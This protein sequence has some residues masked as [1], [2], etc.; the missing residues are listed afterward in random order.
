MHTASYQ[1]WTLGA[2]RDPIGVHVYAVHVYAV[3]VYG[4]RCPPPAVDG[5]P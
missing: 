5:A 3:H 1:T 2:R 4:M